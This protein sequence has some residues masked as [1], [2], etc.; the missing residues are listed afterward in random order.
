MST[1]FT[2]EFLTLLQQMFAFLGTKIKVSCE[3]VGKKANSMRTLP[4]KGVQILNVAGLEL[5]KS[6]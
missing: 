2:V 6:R 5:V 1:V 4:Q 3:T